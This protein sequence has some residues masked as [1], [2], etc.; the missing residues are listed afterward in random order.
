MTN[1]QRARKLEYEMIE[2]G[3]SDEEVEA[4]VEAFWDDKIERYQD[5]LLEEHFNA[6]I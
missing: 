4:A 3:Y 5:Q 1:N 2:E 6:S